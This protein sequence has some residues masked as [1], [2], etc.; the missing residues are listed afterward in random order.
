MRSR[1]CPPAVSHPASSARTAGRRR[2]ATLVAALSLAACGS[3]RT[4]P[5]VL[6]VTLDTVR[7]DRLGCYGHAGAATPRLDELAARGVRFERAYTTAPLTL[8]AHASILTGTYPVFHGVHD[9]GSYR[10]DDRLTTVA[11]LLRPQGYRTAAFVGAY[12]VQAHF[13]LSQ[14]FEV[15]DDRLERPT[16]TEF[17]AFEERRAGEV[18]D[19]AERWLATVGPAEPFFAWVHLFDPHAIYRPPEPFATEFAGD[20][21]QGEIAYAD[22][23]LG[24][25]FDRLRD[26]GVL[27]RTLVV[28]VADHGEG[29]GD[30]GEDTHGLLIYDTTMRVPLLLAGPGVPSGETV[31]AVSSVAD[32]LPTVTDLLG[33]ETPA[34][35]QGRS[36]APLWRGE[37][38]PGRDAYLES[39]WGRLHFGWSELR[40]LV[41]EDWKYIEAPHAPDALP[42]L[43]RIVDDPRENRDLSAE[44]PDRVAELGAAVESAQEGLTAPTAFD[45]ERAQSAEDR[46]RL[47]AL[48]YVAGTSADPEQAGRH[49]REM[50]QV[51]R[52]Y[53]RVANEVR[54]GRLREALARLDELERLDPG[55]LALHENR[56]LV[57][58][59]L[60]RRDPRYYERAIEELRQALEINA[61]RDDVWKNLA[62]IHRVRGEYDEALRCYEQAF[63]IAPAE[64]D[65]EAAYAGVLGAVGR[66]EEGIRRLTALLEAE[67][68]RVRG[69]LT[70]AMLLASA[71]RDEE[72]LAHAERVLELAT[73]EAPER[74]TAHQLAGSVCERMGR[75]AEAIGHY[76]AAL[77]IAPRDERTRERLTRL[78]RQVN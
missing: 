60:G 74:L 45:A 62:E 31:D 63:E 53:T 75:T 4:P 36:L 57:Y 56:G 59:E 68:T 54:E 42:E 61:R 22:H 55:R 25:L 70:L 37:A 65:V 49:P 52:G 32:L 14:G 27:E 64:P 21:Y 38:L 46:R 73:P 6:L 34:E 72:A 29:L 9:N 40:G 3:P 23:E 77:E 18:I 47:E 69:Q 78:R 28:V 41:R 1:R 33:L 58:K 71:G 44:A 19:A 66:T 10:L 39:L 7:A 67:P 51:L 50:V 20:P 16:D 30:H 76:E 13:G 26:D 11:E 8:P 15:Y 12:P 48:G 2:L 43:F 24:R 35:V 17:Y 5:S